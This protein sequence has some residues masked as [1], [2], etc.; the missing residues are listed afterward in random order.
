M[1]ELVAEAYYIQ[2]NGPLAIIS[3]RLNSCSRFWSWI[4]QKPLPLGCGAMRKVLPEMKPHY[5]FTSIFTATRP[6]TQLTINSRQN[7]L[8]K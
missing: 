2:A 1:V 8:I 3:D 4:E 5:T 7:P 6:P